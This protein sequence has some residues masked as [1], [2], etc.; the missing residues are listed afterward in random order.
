MGARLRQIVLITDDLQPTLAQLREYLGLGGA[1]VDPAMAAFDLEHEVLAVGPDTYLEVCA[2]I[3]LDAATTGTKFLARNNGPGGYMLAI[4]ITDAVAARAELNRL[5]V[6]PMH[7]EELRGNLVTQLHPREFGTLLEADEILTDTDWHYDELSSEVRTDVTTAIVAAELA[8][9][10]PSAFAQRWA[11]VFGLELADDTSVRT[12]DSRLVRFV[13]ITDRGGL[14][15]FD[16]H[17]TDRARAG[18]VQRICG[19]DIRLV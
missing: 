13:P 18:D 16:V 2:P 5:G 1:T 8:V 17:A 14:A 7:Q 9:A 15:A 11:S 4:Q 3:H 12:D 19:V 6:M 10:D